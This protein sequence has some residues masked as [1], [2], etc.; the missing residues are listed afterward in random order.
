[1]TRTDASTNTQPISMW[2]DLLPA[3]LTTP[4]GTQL[5]GDVE[6]D[7]AIIGGG[8]TGLWTAY[9]LQ[10]ADPSLRICVIEANVAGFG[11]SGRN[12]GW[13][14]ALFPASLRQ[15]AERSDRET[16]IRM[17]RTMHDSV[18]EIGR[19]AAAEGWEIEWSKGGTIGIARSP[20]QWRRAEEEIED[21]RAWGFGPEDYSLLT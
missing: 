4:L 13:A 20:L 21:M 15:L 16:A 10:Q 6:Y 9:Y 14:S 12:G 2:W 7:V 19:V 17:K 3:E 18:T 8:Y 1:M 11:A 5:N